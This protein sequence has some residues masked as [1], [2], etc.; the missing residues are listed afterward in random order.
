LSLLLI[1]LV[2]TAPAAGEVTGAVPLR[3]YWDE[4]GA[5][6]YSDVMLIHDDGRAEVVREL[7]G[8]VDGIRMIQFDSQG[9]TLGALGYVPTRNKLDAE[10]WWSNSWVYITPD[11]DGFTR[12]LAFALAAGLLLVVANAFPFA[13]LEAKGLEQVMT[14]PQT[15][16]ELAR[17]G[18]APLVVLVLG[19]IVVV[20]AL[21]LVT[22]VALLVPLRR[23]LSVPWLVPAGRLLFFLSPWSMVE[24][25]VIG[26]LVSLVKIGAM[27]SV[28]LGLS[29]WAYVGFVV[30]FSASLASIDRLATWR[31]IEACTA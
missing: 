9:N 17:G 8:T 1:S 14:L 31:E 15:A 25:F 20:P 26:V 12:S 18:T 13:A 3:S 7:G 21:I 24:V 23:R 4:G 16:V 5:T 28:V 22:L 30:C 27:A 11:S 6:I 29:F 10:L 19:P 2:P